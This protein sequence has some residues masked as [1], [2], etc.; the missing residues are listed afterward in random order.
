MKPTRTTLFIALV[1]LLGLGGCEKAAEPTQ[2]VFTPPASVLTMLPVVTT[3]PTTPTARS[4]AASTLPLLVIPKEGTPLTPLVFT[5]VPPTETP[6]PEPTVKDTY[7]PDALIQILTPGNRSQISSPMKV[8]AS[9]Y[10][11]YGNLV[12]L[13]LVGEDGRLIHDRLLKMVESETGWVNILEE[14]T[15]EIPSAGESAVL[16]ITTRD[17]FDRRV[18]QSV[19]ELFLIQIGK[20]DIEKKVFVKEPYV[21]ITPKEEAVVKGGFVHV[22]GFAH[23]FNTNPIILELLTESGGVME[24]LIIKLPRGAVDQNY[25]PFSADIPYDVEIRTPVRLTIR[26]RSTLMPAYDIALSSRLLELMP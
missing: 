1:I 13:Q 22:E 14:I 11:G 9:V 23:A 5:P 19:R 8:V 3:V 20:S 15:F 12:G 7:F 4:T 17:E 10:P 26:Q 2:E 6:S 16:V 21:L 18:T 25:I 24:T